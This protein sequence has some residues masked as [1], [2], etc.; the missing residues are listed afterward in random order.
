MKTICRYVCLVLF[1]ISCNKDQK[2]I[3]NKISN[4]E[5]EKNSL[6]EFTPH[7][8][9]RL[10]LSD[11]DSIVLEDYYKNEK[12][13]SK[14]VGFRYKIKADTAYTV[15][16]LAKFNFQLKENF[17][18]KHDYKLIFNI[19]NKKH[20]YFIQK[21]DYD[22]IKNGE[23]KHFITKSYFVNGRKFSGYAVYYLE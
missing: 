1:F 11:T 16:K 10:D 21:I 17:I 7:F 19:K 14:R 4:L 5:S 6:I 3:E 20:E 12:K 13:Y 23:T 2:K 22:S 9:T 18:Q 8:I 15:F